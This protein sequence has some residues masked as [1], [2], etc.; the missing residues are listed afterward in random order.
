[1]PAQ[2]LHVMHLEAGRLHLL[3]RMP[4]VIELGAWKDV[5]QNHALAAADTAELALLA[6]GTAGD[7]VIEED[8]PVRQ[9]IADLAEIGGITGDADMLVH[10]DAG[11]LVP[12][13]LQIAVVLQ[14][15]GHAVLQSERC[16]LVLCKFE[17]LLGQGHTVGFRAVVLRRMTQ[18]RAPAATD[19]EEAFAGL[20]AQL[21][22]DEVKFVA[23]GLLE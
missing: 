13:A 16:N 20:Q 15:D 7:A 3:G 9:Q 19:V 18:Q 8:A 17:L 5:L 1:M 6:L 21:A 12:A 14:L 22:A 2:S 4:D 10:A 23:L 11:D